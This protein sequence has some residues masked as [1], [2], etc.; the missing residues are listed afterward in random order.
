MSIKAVSEVMFF[1]A[2][3]PLL[4]KSKHNTVPSLT[5]LVLPSDPV[6]PSS[7]GAPT[8]TVLSMTHTPFPKSSF[9]LTLLPINLSSITY[10]VLYIVAVNAPPDPVFESTTVVSC[11]SNVVSPESNFI[12]LELAKFSA[13]MTN[14][15]ADSLHAICVPNFMFVCELGALIVC[16]SVYVFVEPSAFHL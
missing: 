14:L 11:K 3:S 16:C 9:S 6:F 2:Y 7:W 1:Q 8:T 4:V 12:S 13:P 15:F 10:L 5:T